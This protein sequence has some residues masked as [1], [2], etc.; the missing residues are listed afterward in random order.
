MSFLST[1]PDRRELMKE[2]ARYS[3]DGFREVN[4]HLH[5]PYSFSAFRDIAQIFTLAA[6]EGIDVLGINDFNTADG[7]DRFY[8]QALVHRKFPLFNIEMIGLMEEEQKRN[9]R[10]NDPD[11]PGRAYLCGKGLDYPFAL[12]A[13]WSEKLLLL[14]EESQRQVKEMI[15]KSNRFFRGIGVDVSLDYDEIRTTL[16][17]RLVRERHIARAIRI[18]LFKNTIDEKGRLSLFRKLYSGKEP[19]ASINDEAAVE[20]EIRTRLLKSGG[21]GFVE[22]DPSAFLPVADILSII[23]QAGGF[24]CYPVLLDDQTGSFTEF[25]SDW[26]KLLDALTRMNIGCIELIPARNDLKILNGFVHFFRQK[27][28][29]ITFGTEHNTPRMAPL[30][31]SA[32]NQVPLNSELK[33]ISWEGACVVAAHQFLR[34]KKERG[35]VA[36]EGRARK[37]QLNSFV[38]LGEK[39]IG[40]FFDSKE[41]V[42]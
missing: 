5:T 30:T 18:Q 2:K 17:K 11:N 1:Y 7:Y 22:E 41:T 14:K 19:S 8:D 28:F 15:D 3:V 20:N 6:E 31:V 24:P 29:V 37:D 21:A 13:P 10:V 35:F 27:H 32:R 39:V 23:Q 16:T 9:R 36:R 40:Y 4:A 12:I 38:A 33:R 26:Q 34:A 42:K 25:E